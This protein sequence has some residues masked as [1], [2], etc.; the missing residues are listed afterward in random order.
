VAALSVVNRDVA[1]LAQGVEDVRC[2]LRNDAFI[3]QPAQ[4]F[5]EGFPLTP[6]ERVVGSDQL[7]QKLGEL[8]QF[9][10][11][12]GRVLAEIPLRLPP[13]VASRMSCPLR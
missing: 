6:V 7:R 1:V 3:R 4:R 12:G 8:P 10:D 11:G 13:K 2:L 5:L 9:D